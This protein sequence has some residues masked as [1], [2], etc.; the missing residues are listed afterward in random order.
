M[1]PTPFSASRCF[2][3]AYKSRNLS[4]TPTWGG[5]AKFRGSRQCDAVV[6]ERRRAD[7]AMRRAG[8]EALD[9]RSITEPWSV[10][11]Q[12]RSAQPPVCF[13]LEIHRMR[14]SLQL[15][16]TGGVHSTHLFP[17]GVTHL[18]CVPRSSSLDSFAHGGRESRDLGDE[19]RRPALVSEFW[20]RDACVRGGVLQ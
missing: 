4:L 2:S 11:N 12:L 14:Q 17:A 16:R 15:Q 20:R 3:S 5:F 19:W 6:C 1:P 8:R 10:S 13:F 7:E 18:V 9:R